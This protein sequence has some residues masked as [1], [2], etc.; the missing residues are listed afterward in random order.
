MSLGQIMRQLSSLTPK[1]V[2]LTGG[3]PMIFPG[4]V[5]LAGQIRMAGYHLTV[6]TAGTVWQELDCDLWSIS[7]KLL[8]SA[9]PE[10]TS[11]KWHRLHHQRRHRPDVVQRMMQSEYQ[12]KFVVNS[13]L[14]AEEVLEYLDQLP[15]FESQRVLLM[16]QGTDTE[17]LDRQADWLAP[18]CRRHGLQFCPRQ[19]IYWFG[20]RRGT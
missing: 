19:H 7:P 20:N 8:G 6:E 17:T 4:V 16:P 3:E 14:E 9:P 13:H 5:Q 18:W 1:H 2:V 15:S 12:L 11:G 10:S